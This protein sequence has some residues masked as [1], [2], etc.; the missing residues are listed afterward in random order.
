MLA[1]PTRVVLLLAAVLAAAGP[2]P[3]VLAAQ[4]AAPAQDE[5]PRGAPDFGRQ[6]RQQAETD[7]L[8]REASAGAMRMDKIT[9]R[10]RADGLEIPAFV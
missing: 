10:S 3:G 5:R 2:D 8:W 9:Y 6:R 4:Q 1:R 7:R